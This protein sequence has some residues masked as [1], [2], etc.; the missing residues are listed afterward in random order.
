MYQLYNGY[1][2]SNYQCEICS[3]NCMDCYNKILCLTCNKNYF[4]SDGKCFS[5]SEVI[6]NCKKLVPSQSLCALCDIG[7]YRDEYGQCKNCIENCNECNTEK[8]C[9]SCFTNYFLLANNTQCISYDLLVNCEVKSQSGCLK[10]LTGFYQQNQFC[11]TYNLTTFNCSTCGTTGICT[12][13]VEY[14]ILLD[15]KC[16]S[17][18]SI[19]NC[20]E[21]TNS[22]CTKCAFW[23]TPNY[24]NTSCHTKV[25]WWVILIV[26]IF[27]IIIITLIVFIVLFVSVQIN[28]HYHI[29]KVQEKTCIFDVR[30]SN[31]QFTKTSIS[32]V[33]VNKN[34]IK[35]EGENDE[36][37]IPVDKESREL[38]CVGNF[39]KNTIKV[40]FSSKDNTEK[41][42]IRTEPLVISLKKNKAVEFEIFIRPNCSCKIKDKITLFSVN[43][44][45]G[46]TKETQINLV[47]ITQI[48]TK[49]DNEE[50]NEDKKLG[51]G[52]FGIV[53]KG[54]YK[55]NE[56]AIK[57]LKEMVGNSLLSFFEKEVTM[58]D[59]FRSEYIV[60]FYGAVF[61]PNKVCMVTEFAPFGS[62]QDLTNHKPSS[63]VCIKLRIKMMIDAA[64]A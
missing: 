22:K 9:L 60:H 17:K 34:Q 33:F 23:H 38:L 49:L 54:T 27:V 6:T 51:E 47:A 61:I 39:G 36:E 41:Y 64:N 55:G 26:V 56:V 14:Y 58:L 28:R 44:K 2:L 59:K 3:E 13:C 21:V 25:V 37:T 63:D 29:K 57:K 50:L 30:K 1:F 7:F 40:Q 12:S 31:I 20:V 16:Y 18:S 53:Y 5:N 46:I 11:V 32:D 19:E 8:T 35:F 4:L 62:L 48:S 52:G 42:T 43:F 10:C 15:S 45:S 24:S